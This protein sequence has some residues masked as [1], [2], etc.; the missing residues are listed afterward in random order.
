MTAPL[1]SVLIPCFNAERFVGAALE[2]VLA[3]T[4]RPI[5]VIVVDDNST[6]NS[7]SVIAEYTARGVK[8]LAAKRTGA[9]AARNQAFLA[10]TGQFVIFLDA[11]DAII[12][13]HVAALVDRI[14]GSEA[15]LAMGP[16]GRFNRDPAECAFPLR[17][18]YREATGPEWLVADWA[19]GQAMTQC[20]QFLIPRGLL[21]KA[22]GWD[23]SL[24][25][26]DDFEFFARLMVH[27]AG[28]LFAPKAGLCYRIVSGSLSQK[29]SPVGNR[30]AVHS[31]V[32]GTGHLLAVDSSAASRLACANMLKTLDYAF[33]PYEPALRQQLRQRIADLGGSSLAPTGPP[34]FQ[35]LRRWIG[36]KAARRL[37]LAAQRFGLNRAA[38][39]PR[40]R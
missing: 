17:R 18:S 23:E 13:T 26:L 20:G 40:A 16:W 36:W 34:A 28:V 24:T 3:Q 19:E 5:E 38:R 39:Q 7:A 9:A 30:S 27:S 6:D 37:Q 15:K 4:Y 12:E 31:L 25:V 29:S 1:V 35:K 11:D 22:G 21:E 10:S 8:T 2:S 32:L 14:A 33:Y